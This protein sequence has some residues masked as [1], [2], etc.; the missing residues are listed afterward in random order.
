MFRTAAVLLGLAAG[1]ASVEIGLR[2]LRFDPVKIG[3]KVYLRSS[4]DKRTVYMCYPSNPNGELSRVPD[5]SQGDWELMSASLPPARIPLTE[6]SKTPWCVEDRT[7]DQGLRDRHYDRQPAGGKI[8]IAMVGDSFVR[9]EGVPAD[10]TLPSKLEG[11]LGKEKFEVVNVGFAGAG[12]ED[13]VGYARQIVSRLDVSKLIVVFIPNDIRL[14]SALD[15]RQ[16]Y[17]NDLI[18]IREEH[19]KQHNNRVTLYRVSRVA[20]LIGSY[21]EMRRITGETAQWYLDSYDPAFNSK[22]LELLEGNFRELAALPH[23][24]V[25]LVLYPLMFE[26]ERSYPLQPIHE[27]VAELA[28]KAGL[29][30][31]DLA[32]A[33]HGLK[34]QSIQVNPCDHHPNGRAHAIAAEAIAQ[35]LKKEAPDFF[36]SDSAETQAPRVATPP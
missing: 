12:T 24:R 23:C 19:L 35:W 13:E 21:F 5:I 36:T 16:E 29:R 8:R 7:S 31:L 6:L 32:P 25:T 14:S 1:V 2:A 4:A 15:Q 18:N 34:A 20:A 11:D 9:G 26:L 22:G 17:I 27:K 33:F 3:G 10:K 28:R 30:V